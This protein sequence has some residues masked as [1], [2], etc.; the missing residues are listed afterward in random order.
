[1]NTQAVEDY[2][3]AVHEL[4]REQGAVSTTALADRLGVRP[5]SVSGMMKRLAEMNLVVHEPYQSVT[6]TDA[7]RKIALEVI[8][9]HRLV[10]VYLAEALGVPW[11]QVHGEAEKWEH[12]L[13]EELEDR[14]DEM[15]GHPATDPHGSPIPSR[16]GEM[17]ETASVRLVDLGIGSP[18]VIAEVNDHDAD[19]LRHLGELGLYPNAEVCITD[20]APFEGPLTIRV[21][22]EERVVGRTVAANVY[23]T[24][25]GHP[26]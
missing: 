11:D 18:A 19:L 15:L 9:H 4:E 12:V 7:G 13:S 10:E 26:A 2:L 5:A 6:L 17:P 14:M 1:M 23:V 8:R 25:V 24:E 3:K 20:S 16:E 22:G 21:G